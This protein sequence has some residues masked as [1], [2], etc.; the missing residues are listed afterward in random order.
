MEMKT[1]VRY[2]TQ[3]RIHHS[4]GGSTSF[5]IQRYNLE[6]LQLAMQV[7]VNLSCDS[8]AIT[9]QPIKRI[10]EEVIEKKGQFV[11]FVPKFPKDSLIYGEDCIDRKFYKPFKVKHC[12]SA[13]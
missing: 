8:I 12:G 9:F 3:C 1:I 4:F 11:Q 7:Q 2:S 6:E 5:G 10:T 13:G